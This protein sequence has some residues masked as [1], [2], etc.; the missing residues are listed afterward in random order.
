MYARRFYRKTPPGYSGVLFAPTGEAVLSV[1]EED[2]ALSSGQQKKHRSELS[3][4][5]RQGRELIGYRL[6]PL[7]R[8]D[9]VTDAPDTLAPETS[10]AAAAMR[11]ASTQTSGSASDN[12]ADGFHSGLVL[13]GAL[14]FLLGTG[15]DEESALVLIALLVLLT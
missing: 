11:E 4:R 6:A 3:R 13:I 14:L 12:G 15:L 8:A 10:D 2:K 7:Y 5:E 9:A 1:T